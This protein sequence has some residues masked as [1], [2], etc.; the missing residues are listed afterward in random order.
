MENYIR[1][2]SNPGAV[3]NTDRAGLEAYKKRK[4]RDAEINNLKEE[5]TEI[6]ALLLQLLEKNK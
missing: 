1:S 3:V 4:Q 5:I 2:K 6:K